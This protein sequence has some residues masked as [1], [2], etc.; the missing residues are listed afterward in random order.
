MSLQ[1]EFH[2]SKTRKRSSKSLPV[3]TQEVD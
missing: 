3:F 1:A 2:Y